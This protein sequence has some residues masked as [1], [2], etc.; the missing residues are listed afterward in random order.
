[1]KS[2]KK[3]LLITCFL[4][5]S[6]WVWE[7]KICPSAFRLACDNLAAALA[8]LATNNDRDEIE[9]DQKTKAAAQ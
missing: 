3:I 5:S 2:T 1:M 8:V 7:F 6:M 9:G 4:M